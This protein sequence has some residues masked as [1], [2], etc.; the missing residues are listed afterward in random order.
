LSDD[1]EMKDLDAVKKII[2]MEIHRDSKAEKLYFH[3][4]KST[5]IKYLNT[6]V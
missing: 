4:K 1:F 6:L 5:L 3:K 2:R